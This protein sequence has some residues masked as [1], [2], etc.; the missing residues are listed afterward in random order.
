MKLSKSELEL[1]FQVLA[2]HSDNMEDL[3]GEEYAEDLYDLYI[4]MS[5]QFQ[6]EDEDEY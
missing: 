1:L 5:K 3:L 4:K 6:R 2:E